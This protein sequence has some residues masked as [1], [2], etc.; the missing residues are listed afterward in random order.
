MKAIQIMAVFLIV[1][2]IINMVLLA[3][4]IIQ[5]LAFWTVIILAGISSYVI[6]NHLKPKL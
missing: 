5:D 1:V 6:N 2:L 4:G 3:L